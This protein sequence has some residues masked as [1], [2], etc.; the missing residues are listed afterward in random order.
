MH[1]FDDLDRRL[2]AGAVLFGI[3]W[4]IAGFCPG[5]ALVAVGMGL[6]KA[7]IF[8]AAMLAGMGIFEFLE[9]RNAPAR[10]QSERT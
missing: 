10:S 9:S 2:V 5:P 1:Q 6:P 7:F 3:G 4:G 8:F